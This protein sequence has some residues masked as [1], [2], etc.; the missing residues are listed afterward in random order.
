MKVASSPDLTETGGNMEKLKSDEKG[1]ANLPR[2]KSGRLNLLLILTVKWL[3][4]I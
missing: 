2:K 1:F 4:P 3:G